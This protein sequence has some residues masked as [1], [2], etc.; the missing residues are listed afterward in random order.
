MKKLNFISFILLFSL[1]S[2]AFSGWN[3]ET[4]P[5]GV[6]KVSYYSPDWMPDGKRIAYVKRTDHR[7][8]HY[9]FLHLLAKGNVTTESTDYQICIFDLETNEEKIIQT[10][11]VKEKYDGNANHI[12]YLWNDQK[13]EG[14][15][16]IWGLDVDPV[17][18]QILIASVTSRRWGASSGAIFILKEDGS[19]F[20]KVIEDGLNP[21]W[22]YDGKRIVYGVDTIT[23]QIRGEGQDAVRDE[24]HSYSFRVRDMIRNKDERILEGIFEGLLN[25]NGKM[26]I[27]RECEKL[28][29]CKLVIADIRD[30]SKKEKLNKLSTDQIG[31]WSLDGTKILLGNCIYDY[32]IDNLKN[33]NAEYSCFKGISRGGRLSNDGKKIVSGGHGYL[34]EIIVIDCDSGNVRVVKN[35]YENEFK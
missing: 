35:N 34:E 18:G 5:S 21:R 14:I 23:I 33:G 6:D 24:I 9:D 26:I 29:G 2:S 12:Y 8:Y 11:T 16:E 3:E 4:K 27:Y 10:I 7:K 20:R 15:K 1:A 13:Y 28:K 31:D 17:S 32:D 22:S 25:P 19:D 30:V